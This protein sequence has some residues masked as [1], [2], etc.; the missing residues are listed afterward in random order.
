[1][2]GRLV[3]GFKLI[4]YATICFSKFCE[5][6]LKLKKQYLKKHINSYKTNTNF[7]FIIIG[8][9]SV[10]AI[11]TRSICTSF[12]VL[13]RI[14]SQIWQ[15][16]QFG[17][18]RQSAINAWSD[19]TEVGSDCRS[20]GRTLWSGKRWGWASKMSKSMQN[21]AAGCACMHTH[22]VR[23]IFHNNCTM[24]AMLHVACFWIFWR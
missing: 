12:S 13:F 18:F 22:S 16:R 14:V 4:L 1:M 3:L 11:P 6:S 20:V 23:Q 10:F 19:N 7:S 24:H 9:F 21:A 5:N 8:N 17:W 15:M 2:R